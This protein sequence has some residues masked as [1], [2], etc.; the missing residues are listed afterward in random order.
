MYLSG[1]NYSWKAFC[2]NNNFD[3][4]SWSS[5][6]YKEKVAPEWETWKREWIKRRTLMSDEEIDPLMVDTRKL[7]AH[8]RIKFVQEWSS[9]AKNMKALL[10]HLLNEHVT[11]AAADQRND[12]AHQVV[13]MKKL[14]LNIEQLSD[15][16]AAGNRIA[17][18]EA[19]A[20][21]MPGLSDP[22]FGKKLAAESEGD[23]KGG[24]AADEP[25][26]FDVIPMGSIMNAT[27]RT[28]TIAEYFDQYQQPAPPP[29]EVP[30]LAAPAEEPDAED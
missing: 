20:L 4:M 1:T 26:E 12:F 2:V 5:P 19:R 16:A 17:E 23:G 24:V 9:I 3:P 28:R 18:L 30:A 15:F 11:N 22:N 7:V 8:S 13:G 27:D 14:K 10:V 25:S 29:V 6:W 21:F